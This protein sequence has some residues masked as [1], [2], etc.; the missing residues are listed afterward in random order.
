MKGNNN[1]IMIGKTTVSS[2]N[3]AENIVRK[4]LESNLIACGEI[5]GQFQLFID[6]TKKLLKVM[7]GEYV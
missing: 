2:K 6:G 7:N 5:E 1:T 3:D 4:L